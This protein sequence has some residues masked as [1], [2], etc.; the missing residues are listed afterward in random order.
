M[1]V[2]NHKVGIRELVVIGIMTQCTTCAALLRATSGLKPA[3]RL[4]VPAI[5]DILIYRH[6]AVLGDRIER[7]GRGR[8]LPETGRGI[9]KTG[10]G[11]PRMGLA[12]RNIEKHV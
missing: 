10:L 2:A 3:C 5:P 11:L 4:A 7:R 8:G 12:R 1:Y 6:D 9:P